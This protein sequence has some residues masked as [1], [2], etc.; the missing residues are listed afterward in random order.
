MSEEKEKKRKSSKSG[1]YKKQSGGHACRLE[2]KGTGPR[3]ESPGTLLPR[4]K[5]E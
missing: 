5:K 2:F 4:K 1:H 3:G